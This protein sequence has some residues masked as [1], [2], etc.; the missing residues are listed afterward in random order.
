MILKRAGLGSGYHS[1]EFTT[2]DGLAFAP[3]SVKVRGSIDGIALPLSAQAIAGLARVESPDAESL[4]TRG[5]K[6]FNRFHGIAARPPLPGMESEFAE[7][8]C[9]SAAAAGMCHSMLSRRM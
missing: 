4:R 6:R 3:L 7:S 8:F 5:S 2:P 1:F 9:Y